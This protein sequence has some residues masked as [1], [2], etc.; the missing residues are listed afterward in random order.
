MPLL[1]ICGM[2]TETLCTGFLARQVFETDNFT[3]VPA[4]L[5][6]LRSRAVTRLTPVAFS[7]C[8]FEMRSVLEVL[9]IDVFMTCYAGI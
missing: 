1:Q 5:H 6:M 3:D 9:L 8:G 4:A 2:A 7:H